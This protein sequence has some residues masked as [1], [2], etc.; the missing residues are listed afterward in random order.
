MRAATRKRKRHS[1]FDRNYDVYFYISQR[2]KLEGE[3]EK[4][5]FCAKKRI[6]V[7]A[8]VLMATPCTGLQG[9]GI[10]GMMGTSSRKEMRRA[11]GDSEKGSERWFVFR[12]SGSDKNGGVEFEVTVAK[13]GG[14]SLKLDV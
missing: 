11:D 2:I 14:E 4:T 9:V 10:G 5:A 6:S 3:T 1:C 7:K 8:V 13:T 12:I